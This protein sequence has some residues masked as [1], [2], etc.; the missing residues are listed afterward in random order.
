MP[1]FQFDSF[2]VTAAGLVFSPKMAM[3]KILWLPACLFLRLWAFRLFVLVGL[4][5]GTVWFGAQLTWDFPPKAKW[6]YGEV[7]HL[8]VVPQLHFSKLWLCFGA[9]M[10]YF[11]AVVVYSLRRILPFYSAI[12]ERWSWNEQRPSHGCSV[13]FFFGG[14]EGQFVYYDLV[15]WY[16]RLKYFASVMRI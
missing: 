6:T 14:G 2:Y 13:P 5:R 9:C 4:A 15:E 1:V 3:L 12:N 8:A 11:F 7:F 10:V 16:N